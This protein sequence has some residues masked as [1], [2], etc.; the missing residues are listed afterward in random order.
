MYEHVSLG[1]TCLAREVGSI[2]SVKTADPRKAQF[3]KLAKDAPSQQEGRAGDGSV[4]TSLKPAKSIS[5]PPEER[6]GRNE[7]AK[8]HV[9]ALMGLLLLQVSH[10]VLIFA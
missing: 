6:I 8:S 1:D 7:A 4:H 5:A 3:N 2:E 10:D 9:K